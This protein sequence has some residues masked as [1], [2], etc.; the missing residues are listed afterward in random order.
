MRCEGREVGKASGIFQG[1]KVP[2]A[3][4]FARAG[5]LSQPLTFMQPEPGTGRQVPFAD[6]EAFK[7]LSKQLCRCVLGKCGGATWHGQPVND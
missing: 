5:S 6:K 2:G 1:R 7:G 3:A 4:V